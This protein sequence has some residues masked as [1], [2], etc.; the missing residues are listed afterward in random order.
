MNEF[1]FAIMGA[2]NIANKFYD[3]VR[4]TKGACIAAVAS[5]SYERAEAFALKHRI[6]GYYDDYEKML[7]EEKPDC[8]YIATTPDSHYA[9]CRLCV[10]H[11]VAVICEKA[12]FANASEATKLFALAEEKGVFTMEAMWS[13]FLPANITARNWINEGRIG[14]LISIDT[15]IGFVSKPDPEIRFLNPRLCGGATTDITVYGY[16]L[17]TWMAQSS[18][19]RFHVEA[20][21]G[22]TGVDI[23]DT[24]LLAFENGAHGIVKTS[25]V[26]RLNEGM[27]IHGT[28]GRIAIPHPHYANEA[29]LYD[30]EKKRP[31]EH[32]KDKC[33]N[34]F[35][36][37]VNE[38]MRCVN[39]GRIESETIPHKDTIECA[40]IFDE[41]YKVMEA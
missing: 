40:A 33:P 19:K 10:E 26:S 16:E 18:V 41:V 7:R 8:V 31:L 9:L 27:V 14:E 3:A 25:I 22:E 15:S 32:F 28:K 1:R 23:T 13:R 38:V 36:F 20:V 11:G 29:F 37:E 6:P 21:K 4:R 17:T 30:F 2:G 24:I 35:I 34:G 12:M 5:K 39:E